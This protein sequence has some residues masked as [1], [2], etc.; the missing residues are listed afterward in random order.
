MFVNNDTLNC[1]I[2]RDIRRNKLKKRPQNTYNKGINSHLVF[3]LR[4]VIAGPFD[5]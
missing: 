2:T 1:G 4:S 3:K 5:V